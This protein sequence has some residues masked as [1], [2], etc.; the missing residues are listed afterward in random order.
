VDNDHPNEITEILARVESGDESAIAALLPKV[1]SELRAL[2]GSYFKFERSEHTLQ[3]TALVHEAYLR[4]AGAGIAGWQSRAHFFAIAAQAMR[5][6]LIEHARNK[7]TYKQGGGRKR[8]TLSGMLTPPNLEAQID[9]VA[10][11]E[12][13]TRLAELF[14]RQGRIVEMRILSGLN[15]NE[16][17]HVLDVTTRTVQREWRA[18]KAFLRVELKG[19]LKS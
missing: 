15:E 6:I 2:A 7:K 8:V 1:Y 16:V 13:M 3:P 14:P 5:R 18:A 9:L 10:L 17:A 4:M 19:D 12:A 11:D